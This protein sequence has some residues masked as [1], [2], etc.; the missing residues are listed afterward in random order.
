MQSLQIH[1]RRL[2][3]KG[4]DKSASKYICLK[5]L[6]SFDYNVPSFN[7]QQISVECRACSKVSVL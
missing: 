7:P 2:E 3:N 1:D 5:T 4:N 6:V